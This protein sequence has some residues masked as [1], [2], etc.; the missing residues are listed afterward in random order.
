MKEMKKSQIHSTQLTKSKK[1]PKTKEI[2][3][4]DKKA[5]NKSLEI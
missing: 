1:E 4:V 2:A 3:S 5:L